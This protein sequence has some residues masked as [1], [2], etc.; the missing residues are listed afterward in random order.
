[1]RPRTLAPCFVVTAPFHAD[2]VATRFDVV[3]AMIPAS[4]QSPPTAWP[5]TQRAAWFAMFTGGM[6][7]PN[8]LAATSTLIPGLRGLTAPLRKLPSVVAVAI[9]TVLGVGLGFGA[10]VALAS[11]K[12]GAG[13]SK[14][15]DLWQ[16]LQNDPQLAL[17][18]ALALALAWGPVIV[19]LVAERLGKKEPAAELAS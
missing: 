19:G 6:F 2:S 17:P 18:I 16:S 12:I 11:A 5:E 15:N 7:F 13:V 3:T 8:Y 9:A 1:M 14:A 10:V 4:V